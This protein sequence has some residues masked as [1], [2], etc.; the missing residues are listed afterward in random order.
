VSRE[1]YIPDAPERC[2]E[3]GEDL[4][5][6]GECAVVGCREYEI[7][8][9]GPLRYEVQFHGWSVPCATLRRAVDVRRGQ[10]WSRVVAWGHS[11]VD[12]DDDGLTDDERDA[13]AAPEGDGKDALIA[14]LDGLAAARAA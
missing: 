3:C 13:I 14:V 4:D 8:V 2:P 1:S 7:A 5:E 9:H 12:E 11:P 10:P 6:R